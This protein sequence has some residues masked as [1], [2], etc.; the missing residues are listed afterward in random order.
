MNIFFFLVNNITCQKVDKKILMRKKK[1]VQKERAI[2]FEDYEEIK[3]NKMFCD[4][5]NAV[6]VIRI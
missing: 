3:R 6:N 5:K 2:F 4:V 1:L